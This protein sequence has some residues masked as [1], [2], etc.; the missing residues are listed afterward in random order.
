MKINPNFAE[1]YYIR[2]V[3]RASSGDIKGATEDY[4]QALKINPN[5]VPINSKL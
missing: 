4:N 2:G 1:A 3:L 5:L